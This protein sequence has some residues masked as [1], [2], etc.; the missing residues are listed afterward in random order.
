MSMMITKENTIKEI[1][2]RT[3]VYGNDYHPFHWHENIEICQVLNNGGSFLVDGTLIKA[4]IGDIV[5]VGEQVVHQFCIEM[6]DTLIRIFQLSPKVLMDNVN[7]VKTHITSDEISAVPHLRERLDTFFDIVQ[8]DGGAER[9][10][11]VPY[12]RT[13]AASVYYMLMHHFPGDSDKK[14]HKERQ[15]FYK[16]TDYVNNH[17]AE[18]ISVQTIAEKLYVSRGK[19]GK[20][21]A[22]YSGTPMA[23][24]INSVRIKNVNMLIDSG[25]SVTEAAFESGFQNIRTF[26]EVYKKIMGITPTQY[27]KR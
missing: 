11:D 16:L 22:K 25:L 2:C 14:P 5:V 12:I 1:L 27:I 20:I 7:A 26:N 15:L 13:V 6:P 8:A 9:V 18:N 24:Y 4:D 19:A 17:F 23:F 21:F 10:R 3:S